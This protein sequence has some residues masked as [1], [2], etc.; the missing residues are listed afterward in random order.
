[1]SNFPTSQDDSSTLPNPIAGNFTTAPDHAVL[2]STENDAIKALEAK[3][4]IGASTSTNNTFLI[5]NGT[6]TSTW[7]NLTSAQLAARVSDETG[8]G[9]LVF[10]TSPNIVTPTGMVKGDVGLGNVDNTSDTTK[11]AASVTL[12]NKTMDG[13]SNTFTNIPIGSIATTSGAWATWSP[14][15][16]NLTVGNGTLNLAKYTQTGK[17][18]F[19]RLQLTFGSTTSISGTVS[20][21][22]P[23]TGISAFSGYAECTFVDS[24]A[25]TSQDGR[26]E[27]SSTTTFTP[28]SFLVSGTSILNLT[29][30][31]TNPFTWATS[32]ALRVY[33]YYEAA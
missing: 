16:T 6:G 19:F 2:H 5:G 18:V 32:D 27:M 7:S 3:L 8:S 15:W 20:F 22:L 1:M 12:T 31:A 14:T 23:V 33:G 25:S 30:S 21:S 17:T 28:S 24:S 26:Q 13:A 11:N 9:S 4:G 10:G 29:M